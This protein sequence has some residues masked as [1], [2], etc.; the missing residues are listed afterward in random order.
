MRRRTYYVGGDEQSPRG[1][2]H[3]GGGEEG[4]TARVLNLTPTG[5]AADGSERIGERRGRKRP[6]D[7]QLAVEVCLPRR[8]ERS[9]KRVLA[10][11]V[12]SAPPVARV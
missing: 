12:R 10:A 3:R 9:C 6:R 8:S 5:S 4:H 2:A 11:D 1:L 7:E